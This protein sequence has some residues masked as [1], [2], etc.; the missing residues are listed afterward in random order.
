MNL[1]GGGGNNSLEII[2]SALFDWIKNKGGQISGSGL[3]I[4]Y[5]AIEQVEISEYRASED[6]DIAWTVWRW[7]VYS[8]KQLAKSGML[9]IILLILALFGA[10]IVILVKR[11][12]K[13]ATV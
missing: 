7:I 12:K 6:A 3:E 9:Y 13:Q 1:N 4:N 5:D 8:L 2:K 10:G 11:R